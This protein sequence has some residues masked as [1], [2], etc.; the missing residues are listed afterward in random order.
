LFLILTNLVTSNP[1]ILFAGA[2]FIRLLA[3]RGVSQSFDSYGHIYYAKEL[4]CQKKGPFGS[5]KTKVVWGDNLSLPFMWNWL[6][7]FLPLSIVSKYQKYFNPVIDAFFTLSIYLLAL[8]IGFEQGDALLCCGLYLLTPMWFSRL[9]IGPRTSSFT[10]RLSGEIF[11]NIFFCVTILPIGAPGWMSILL[12]SVCCF[13]VLSSSKFGVQA[14][15]FLTPLVSLFSH[16]LL[17]IFSLILGIFLLATISEGAFLISLKQQLGHLR[18]Y[19]Y[20][21]LKGETAISD[22]NKLG[23]V[24]FREKGVAPS[25]YILKIVRLSLMSNSFTGVLL[26]MPIL[27]F[28]IAGVFFLPRDAGSLFFLEPVFAGIIVYILINIPCFLFLGEAERYLNHVAIFIVFGAVSLATVLQLQEYLWL[29][30]LYGFIYLFCEAFFLPRLLKKIIQKQS[31][32]DIIIDYLKSQEKGVV[33][34]YPYHAGGGVYRIMA[35]TDHRTVLLNAITEDFAEKYQSIYE[36]KYPFADLSK[37]DDMHIDFGVD[38]LI[39]SNDSVAKNL[40][41]NWRPSNNWAEVSLG[42]ELEK[43]YIYQK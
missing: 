31:E 21:N 42:C 40:K 17:P 38:I 24:W 37:L 28:L 22:R 11:T 26:K 7:G 16:T 10:P 18:W 4:K 34:S 25:K 1:I 19:F 9:S 12:G 23:K 3:G 30:L 8:K 39:V 6:I 20:K 41:S 43:V 2:L 5:I 27:V 14:L 32:H 15:L 36:D 35:E 13:Y 33:L 29:F